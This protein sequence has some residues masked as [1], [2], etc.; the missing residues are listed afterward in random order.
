[1]LHIYLH[2]IF[3]FLFVSVTTGKIHTNKRWCIKKIKKMNFFRVCFHRPLGFSSS[4]LPHKESSSSF[5]YVL[6][7]SCKYL[8]CKHFCDRT[9]L[10]SLLLYY[11]CSE[12]QGREIMRK[13]WSRTIFQ[14][15]WLL[16][17]VAST[18]PP[19]QPVMFSWSEGLLWL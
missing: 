16:G 3:F 8:S 13:P 7:P 15:L 5:C 11:C 2:C 9:A 17:T 10:S 12:H 4:S 1:M 6:R 18:H 19:W 14:F